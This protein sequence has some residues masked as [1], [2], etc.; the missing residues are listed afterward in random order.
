MN[1][2]ILFTFCNYVD[3]NASSD[4]ALA[5]AASDVTEFVAK[6]VGK[7]VPVS[8]IRGHTRVLRVVHMAPGMDRDRGLVEIRSDR[9]LN[10][11]IEIGRLRPHGGHTTQTHT[12]GNIDHHSVKQLA[13][14]PRG[15]LQQEHS[16]NL[17]FN[18]AMREGP[19][20]AKSRTVLIGN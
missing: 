10:C 20:F 3:G 19:S 12:K 6:A 16:W 14:R 11:V 13:R 8:V 15:A 17:H 9:D 5:G 2:K 18:Y 1:Y 7:A 4:G